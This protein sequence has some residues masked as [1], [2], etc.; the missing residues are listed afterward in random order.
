LYSNEALDAAVIVPMVYDHVGLRT[1]STPLIDADP[2]GDPT[3]FGSAIEDGLEASRTFT[4]VRLSTREA[5][6]VVNAEVAKR[7]RTRP[8]FFER[9]VR[10][11]WVTVRRD[12]RLL[13]RRVDV[14]A[15]R[16]DGRGFVPISET[17]AT[18]GE[19][20]IVELGVAVCE[21]LK[22]SPVG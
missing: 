12:G 13:V 15:G 6:R 7:L 8:A 1:Y 22:T 2:Q 5:A 10:V 14:A 21:R 3:E 11:A 9:N 19:P 4:A 16:R 20:T 17:R 18:L